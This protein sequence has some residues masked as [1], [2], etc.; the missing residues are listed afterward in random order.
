MKLAWAL[1]WGSLRESSRRS[2]VLRHSGRGLD[3][4][5]AQLEEGDVVLY[6]AGSWLVDG[7]QVGT[8]V[9][10]RRTSLKKIAGSEDPH[11]EVAA[12]SLVQLVFT[13]NCEHGWIYAHPCSV[14]DLVVETDESAEV[15][16]G[17]EQLVAILG[18]AEDGTLTADARAELES[19]AAALN[20]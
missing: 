17:P 8:T 13:H 5:S 14:S 11:I 18:V 15:Q 20:V 4:L 12:V 19:A 16:I 10:T 9:S 1:W 6:R 3:H 7:V 2:V